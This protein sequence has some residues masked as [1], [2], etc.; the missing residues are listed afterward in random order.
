MSP[1]RGRPKQYDTRRALQA[2]GNLFWA[3]G[4]SGTSLDDLSIAMG[5]NRPSIYRAF[6]DKEAL[7]RS[8]MQQYTEHLEEGFRQTISLEQDIRKGLRRFFRTA[9]EVYSAGEKDLGCMVICTAPAAAA[10]H[11]EVK[12]DLL[13]VIQELD[14]R[15]LSRLKLA[16]QQGQLAETADPKMLSK[17]IQAVLHS[18]AIRVRAGES[19]AS[20]Q[21]MADAAVN[22]LLGSAQASHHR[23]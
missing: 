18:L 16:A 11:P 13:A 17:L 14:T 2:A 10:V 9:L 8:A 23:I 5:M 4:F 6:G 22:T 1:Q 12:S 20:V 15:L 21:R 7:Y 19:K 3:R